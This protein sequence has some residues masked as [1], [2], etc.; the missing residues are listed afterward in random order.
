[1]RVVM[2]GMLERV[3]TDAAS[4]S[5]NSANTVLV[6]TKSG[7]VHS[8]LDAPQSIRSAHDEEDGGL[9]IEDL[10]SATVAS[11]IRTIIKRT[12]R[13][14]ECHSSDVS[15]DDGE[16]ELLCV[17]QGRDRVLLI[18]RDMSRHK[19]SLAQIRE[20]AYTD[21][22]TSL[23]NREFLFLEL[24][25]ITAMQN[26]KGGRAALIGLQVDQFS[27][28]G[29]TLAPEEE[30]EIL[31][32]LADRLTS[33]IRGMN[34]ATKCEDSRYSVVARTDFRRF[35]IAL[36]S[37][38]SG[39]DAEA[40]VLRV[41]QAM[42][43]PVTIGSR[44]VTVNVN[45]GIAL[46]PQDGTDAQTLYRN[47]ITALEE[48][49]RSPSKRFKFHSGTVRLR[50]LQRQDL[51]VELKAALDSDSYELNFLPIVAANGGPVWSMEALLRWPETILGS[52]PTRKIVTVAE[53]TGLIVPIGNWV[54][55]R[56]CSALLSWREA[57]HRDVSLAVNLSAQEL[58][59][60]D[61]ARRVEA[62]LRDAD[63]DPAWLN[64]EI[65]EHMLS[66]DA[67]KQFAMCKDL[68]T[69]GVNVVVDD[70]GTGSCSLAQLSQS[71]VD[72]IKI[73][74]SLVARV[75]SCDRSRAACAAAVALADNLDIAVIAEGVETQR[76]A[77]ILRDQGCDYLQGFLFTKPLDADRVESYLATSAVADSTIARRA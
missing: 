64:V 33:Q 67:M 46:F 44:E 43:D 61:L 16:Y 7:S 66:R 38:D 13:S 56:A 53:H 5:T 49:V 3:A 15:A 51:A 41:L 1:M 71:P 57:G 19:T 48:A 36:P 75:G 37:I 34:D 11:A 20:L 14:R 52:Q 18:V 50:S 74:N 69:I 4:E 59:R 45:G 60:E 6:V 77:D 24:G 58:S 40:A 68:K 62:I 73:D 22:A 39:E 26:L 42:E 30:H 2:Q 17:A 35:S 21:E 9:S 72:A 25:K 47:A 55:R 65:K 76:Q 63:I 8:V 10:W 32:E 31:R 28:H 70:Y 27:D 54:L 12:L 23:P 29:H